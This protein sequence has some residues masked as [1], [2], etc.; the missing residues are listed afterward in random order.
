M[1]HVPWLP[2]EQ[3]SKS[4]GTVAEE[5]C[6]CQCPPDPGERALKNPMYWRA[7]FREPSEDR[8]GPA[9]GPTS[10]YSDVALQGSSAKSAIGFS[11]EHVIA[12]LLVWSFV[13]NLQDGH[14][15]GLGER[16]HCAL[17]RVGVVGSCIEDQGSW[18][19]KVLWCV[20]RGLPK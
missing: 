15:P 8:P 9:I 5:D 1:H 13:V 4:P 10:K 2:H 17:Q 20:F 16:K 19:A 14:G 12:E 6:R 3:V 18:T 7:R 11:K